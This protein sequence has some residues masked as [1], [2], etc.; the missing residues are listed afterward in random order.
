MRFLHTMI[1][2][3]DLEEILLRYLRHEADSTRDYPSG[4]FTIAFVD[5]AMRH[6][7]G[8]RIN[9]QLGNSSV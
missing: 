5:M 9:I 3:N 1:R 7:H 4:K 8:H 6:K 2:V